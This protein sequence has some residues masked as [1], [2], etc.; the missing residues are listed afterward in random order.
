[1][2]RDSSAEMTQSRFAA[3]VDAY[4]GD[5]ARWPPDERE[6]AERWLASSS[7]AQAQVLEA[8]DLDRTL[9]AQVA[10]DVSSALERRLMDGFDRARQRRSLGEFYAAAADALWP[11]APAW[12]PAFVLG[13]A[14]AVGLC[15]AVFAPLDIPQPDESAGS[16]FALDSVPDA[17]QGI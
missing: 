1:M 11:G 5:P 16:V 13:M 6:A 9:A 4:G 17:G 7:A 15:I 12:Q 3:I 10:P 8:L 2:R 14:L